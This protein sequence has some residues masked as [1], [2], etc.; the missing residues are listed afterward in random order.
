MNKNGG[1]KSGYITLISAIIISAIL[2]VIMLD[3]SVSGFYARLSVLDHEKKTASF[4][5][6]MSCVQKV[7]LLLVE[8]ENYMG[9]R[10]IKTADGKCELGEILKENGDFVFGVNAG[11]GNTHTASTHLDAKVDL[12]TH[13][14]FIS[15]NLIQ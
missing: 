5:L 12:Q 1:R 7:W 2:M 14:L 13:L 10:I 11:I 8:D 9:G 3:Q 4:Y 6:A 15:E